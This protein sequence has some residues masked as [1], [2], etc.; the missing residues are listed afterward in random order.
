MEKNIIMTFGIQNKDKVVYFTLFEMIDLLY[1][2]NETFEVCH[3][4]EEEFEVM[5]NQ[6][7]K[8]CLYERI[9]I[10]RQ[11]DF[12]YDSKRYMMIHNP[13]NHSLVISDYDEKIKGIYEIQEDKINYM[14][15][16]DLYNYVNIQK[17]G[18]LH[19]QNYKIYTTKTFEEVLSYYQE[20]YQ[21]EDGNKKRLKK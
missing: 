18:L 9:T 5:K 1:K 11:E 10:C 21:K 17:Y 13:K 15:N 2:G 20:L 3:I 19:P 12:G 16:N 14:E 7:E 8:G 4:T 6:L